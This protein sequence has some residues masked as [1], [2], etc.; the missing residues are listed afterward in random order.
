MLFRSIVTR[1]DQRAT[2][3]PGGAT[4]LPNAEVDGLLD[5]LVLGTRF[6]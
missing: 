1:F 2:L 3:I 4:F 5:G 6:A